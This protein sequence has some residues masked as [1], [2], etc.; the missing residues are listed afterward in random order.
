[1]ASSARLFGK[2]LHCPLG[3]AIEA[4][5]RELRSWLGRV[6]D[7]MQ[8]SARIARQ[9]WER[10]LTLLPFGGHHRVIGV[11][12]PFGSASP[13]DQCHLLNGHSHGLGLFTAKP[14]SPHSCRML[15][16]GSNA[17]RVQRA[18]WALARVKDC[19]EVAKVHPEARYFIAP[20]DMHGVTEQ[21][22]G[23]FAQHCFDLLG[24]AQ[25]QGSTCV[26]LGLQPRNCPKSSLRC[27]PR[28]H[29]APRWNVVPLALAGPALR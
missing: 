6:Q 4:R 14:L 24:P 28:L 29:G 19:P 26:A 22:T 27:F 9:I 3:V 10:V 12:Q 5:R 15:A 18:P 16:S 2:F 13:F 1:M 23:T 8:N 21:T 25:I 20:N 11:H 7:P 17:L